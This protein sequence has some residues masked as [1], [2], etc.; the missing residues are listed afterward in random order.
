M[1]SARQMAANRRNAIGHGLATRIHVVLPGEDQS[2]YNEILESLQT[3][4]ASATAQEEMAVHHISQ[5]FWRLIRA[6][7]MESG[8]FKLSLENVCKEFG[9]STS[10]SGDLLRSANLAVALAN[11]EE[12]FSQVNRCET[13]AGRSYYRAIREPQKPQKSE[14][15]RERK[16]PVAPAQVQESA[17]VPEIRSVPQS[18]PTPPP[19]TEIRSVPQYRQADLEKASLTMPPKELNAFIDWLIAPPTRT[20]CA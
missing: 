17:S 18:E 11:N 7:N 19:A 14:L 15:S 9:A 4:Y 3:E 6:R 16:Q 10:A 13:A 20:N 2:F 8:S 5:N 12:F 1:V